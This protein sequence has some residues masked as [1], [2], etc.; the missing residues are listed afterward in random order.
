MKKLGP[1][2][3]VIRGSTVPL[4]TFAFKTMDNAVTDPPAINC[5]LHG[6]NRPLGTN[7]F[8]VTIDRNNTIPSRRNG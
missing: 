2:N 8:Y 5:R 1:I 7:T 4:G 6:G 3:A